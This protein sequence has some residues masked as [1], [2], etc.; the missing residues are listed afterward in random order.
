MLPPLKPIA[1]KERFPT[2]VGMNRPIDVVL[3]LAHRAFPTPV[4]MNRMQ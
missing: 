2:P 1:M 3:S 4:G